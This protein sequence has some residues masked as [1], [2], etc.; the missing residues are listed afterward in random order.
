MLN[1]NE[2]FLQKDMCL[3]LYQKTSRLHIWWFLP[4]HARSPLCV[5]MLIKIILV[6]MIKLSHLEWRGTSWHG[7]PTFFTNGTENTH[8]PRS[9]CSAMLSHRK[10]FLDMLFAENAAL[11]T[12]ANASE[13]LM[14]GEKKKSFQEIST[15]RDIQSSSPCTDG[16]QY[17][18]PNLL[19]EVG[20]S[21]LLQTAFWRSHEPICH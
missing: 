4:P 6:I 15:F 2:G 5:N 17:L 13:I 12:K 20:T 1:R 7:K 8:P 16:G 14:S 11:A 19:S 3:F 18:F 9:A 21:L 10:L